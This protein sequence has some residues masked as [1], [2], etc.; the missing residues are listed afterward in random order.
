MVGVCVGLG[1]IVL[2]GLVDIAEPLF[3]LVRRQ[4]EIEKA[5]W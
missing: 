1:L 3:V 4:R 2:M 5:G